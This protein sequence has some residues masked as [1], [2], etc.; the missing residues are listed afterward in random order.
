MCCEYVWP[1]TRLC[2]N[3]GGMIGVEGGQFTCM[4]VCLRLT[5][6]DTNMGCW[7][8]N[9]KSSIQPSGTRE[10]YRTLPLIHKNMDRI[11]FSVSTTLCTSIKSLGIWKYA[12]ISATFLC[13]EESSWSTCSSVSWY[14]YSTRTHSDLGNE[15]GRAPTCACVCVHMHVWLSLCLCDAHTRSFPPI[16]APT[17]AKH[18]F[19]FV[20]NRWNIS[21]HRIVCG[22]GAC[23]MRAFFQDCYFTVCGAHCAYVFHF[24]RYPFSFSS[25]QLFLHVVCYLLLVVLLDYAL[26]YT[27][28]LLSFTCSSHVALHSWHRICTVPRTKC[29][30]T[31]VRSA[32]NSW[33]NGFDMIVPDIFDIWL[34]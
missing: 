8:V 1:C 22:W 30:S 32:S 16:E 14:I 13:A 24:F 12:L 5:S 11:R 3:R 25:E 10:T 17:H 19:T 29:I 28:L 18:L 9:I 23:A 27:R 2:A 15:R 33:I 4:S 7:S 21:E 6:T 26:P 20:R 31:A 34:N